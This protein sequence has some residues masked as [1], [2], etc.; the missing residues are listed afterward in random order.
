VVCVRT[1]GACEDRVDTR[2]K[3]HAND[4]TSGARRDERTHERAVGGWVACLLGGDRG[5]R[6]WCDD[7][8]MRG[9]VLVVGHDWLVAS[10]RRLVVD[11][12]SLFFSR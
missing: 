9:V 2:T 8:V 1:I 3:G 10:L 4:D 11:P 5:G 7:G 6:M 12:S